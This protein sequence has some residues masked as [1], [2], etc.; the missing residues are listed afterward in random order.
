LEAVT[1]PEACHDLVERRLKWSK[2]VLWFW[3]LS[4]PKIQSSS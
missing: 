3:L 2:I 1:D 4:F